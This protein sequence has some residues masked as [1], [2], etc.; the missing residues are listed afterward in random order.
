MSTQLPKDVEVDV[1]KKTE[2]D[3]SMAEIE[4]VE[5]A[6]DDGLPLGE[7]LEERPARY[8]WSRTSD[9]LRDLDSIATQPS[10]FDNPKTVD[11]YRPPPQ[12]ENAH[13]FDPNARWT[14]REERVRYVWI[15]CG[16]EELMDKQKLVR[17]V[18][19]RI[20]FWACSYNFL[21]Y[22]LSWH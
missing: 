6:L 11:I 14:W 13:R 5:S 12:Y 20:M 10:V 9:T 3:S 4:K 7:P 16:V 8:F 21:W 1:L 22:L 18:D 15:M 17:K 2:E 19:I